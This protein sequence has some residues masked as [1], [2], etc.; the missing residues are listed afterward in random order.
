MASDA[1]APSDIS[2]LWSFV[3]RTRNGDGT[4]PEVVPLTLRRSSEF[5]FLAACDLAATRRR[6]ASEATIPDRQ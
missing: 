2:P 3:S 4:R 6:S 5:A 1:R